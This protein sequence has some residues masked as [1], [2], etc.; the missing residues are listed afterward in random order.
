MRLQRGFSA[1]GM[2][3]LP[4]LLALMTIWT[5]APGVRG[6]LRERTFDQLLP[7]L[8][9]PPI[10]GAGVVIVDIDRAALAKFGPW[11]WPRARLAQLVDAVAS[12][13]PVAIGLDILLAGPDR[14]LSDGNAVL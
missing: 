4:V 1:P 11:P 8:P 3:G 13:K 2:V 5:M 14:F 9:Q 7:L 10:A 6:A 12:A